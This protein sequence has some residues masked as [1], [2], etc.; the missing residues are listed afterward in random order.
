MERKVSRILPYIRAH[1]LTQLRRDAKH[2]DWVKSFIKILDETKK[3]VQQ[4][5]ATGL[6]WNPKVH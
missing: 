6:A 5:H 4:Y 2:V 1:F 3:Y